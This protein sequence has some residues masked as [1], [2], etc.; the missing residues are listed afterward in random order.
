MKGVEA[1]VCQ[2]K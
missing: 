2:N 1:G